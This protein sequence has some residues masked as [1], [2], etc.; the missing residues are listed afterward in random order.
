MFLVAMSWWG[1]NLN[2]VTVTTFCYNTKTLCV[3]ISSCKQRKRFYVTFYNLIIHIHSI[4]TTQQKGNNYTSFITITWKISELI[5]PVCAW[6]CMGSDFI[7]RCN[8]KLNKK[9]NIVYI[10]LQKL[11][12]K[13]ILTKSMLIA[14]IFDL[15]QQ[16]NN[17]CVIWREKT[18]HDLYFYFYKNEFTA[19]LKFNT[20]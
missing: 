8:L 6:Q 10:H 15:N 1:G 18:W 9:T 19:I 5:A 13:N 12:N 2:I 16:W 14:F 17:Y 7:I 4:F 20:S 3:F 11:M